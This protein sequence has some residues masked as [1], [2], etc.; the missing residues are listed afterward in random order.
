MA[1]N[2]KVGLIGVLDMLKFKNMAKVREQAIQAAPAKEIKGDFA[3][4]NNAKLLHPDH[5]KLVVGEIID[6]PGA[7]AKTFVFNSAEGKPLAYFRAGQYLSLKLQIG[8][9]FVT[10]PYSISSSPKWATEGKVAI[11]VRTN[12]G[13]FVAD[14]LLE[15]LKEGDTVIASAGEGQFYYENLRD[16]KNVVALAGGSGITPFLSMA[17]AIRDG[18]EDF[19]L[20]ILFGS[21]TEET[22]LFR[23]EL[24]AICAACPKVKVVHVLSHEEK[25]GFEHGFITAEL[26]KK[27]AQ[28]PYSVFICGPEAMYRFVA[29]EIEKLELPRKNVRRELLG[30]TKSV[31]EQ[32]GYPAECKDKTF[33]LTIHQGPN[34]WTVDAS[35]NEPILVAIERAGVA[36]P[37]RCRSGECGWC[38]SKL[39]SGQFFTPAENEG[40]RH[41]DIVHDYIHPCCTFPLSD[42]VVEVPG[43]FLK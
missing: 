14:W 27:Y 13:G 32:E 3:I 19:N 26:I 2:V 4:N 21:R 25:E 34:Q 10:R 7:G 41:S 17:Y 38:R 31:W 30:V 9:S 35:A 16:A 29:A 39:V 5:Q 37:S 12:P 22:I 15:N 20:T 43:E 8:D 33:K 6:H 24:D 23:Q 42:M 11:T 40:R 1:L 36:A 28:E 18:I